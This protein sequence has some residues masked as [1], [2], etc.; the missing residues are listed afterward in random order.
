MWEQAKISRKGGNSEKCVSAGRAESGEYEGSTILYEF[1]V[2]HVY[3][4]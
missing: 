2:F 1:E 3:F 4:A